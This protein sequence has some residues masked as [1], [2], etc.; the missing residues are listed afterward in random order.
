[1]SAASRFLTM[2]AQALATMSLYR[3]GHPARERAVDR[4]YERLLEL[5]E[6]GPAR[7]FNFLGEDIV[8]E[9]RPLRE[10]RGWDWG[11]RLA[12]AGL[13]RIEFV[14]PVARGDFEAFLDEIFPKVMGARVSSAE[15]R[16]GRP[17]AIRYGHLGVR[18]QEEGGEEAG[19]PPR[20]LADA[21]LRYSLAEE[22]DGVDWLHRE[23]QEGRAL[24]LLEAECIVR[25]LAVAMHS[26]HA[27]LLPILR[28]KEYDQYTVTH[29]LNV[30]VLTM[31]LA[32]FLGMAPREVRA[33]GIAG[34]LHDLGK[35]TIPDDILNK[36]GKLT[37]EERAV[38]NSHTVEGARIILEAEERLDMPAIVAYEHH[39]RIDGGGYPDLRYRRGCHHAS[40]LVHVCDVFDALR[41]DR[42]YR[43]AWSTERALGII[44]EGAG[45]EFDADIAHAFVRMMRQ[46]EDRVAE[47][48]VDD[49]RL[50][51]PENARRKAQENGTVGTG[52]APE[53][54]EGGPEG[55]EARDDPA[56][57]GS[58]AP[59]GL[60]SDAPDARD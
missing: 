32:E 48:D 19:A 30:S 47:V 44:E 54:G 13:Q 18:G 46:W 4:A 7:S 29:A 26:D 20:E 31:A 51:A 17:S 35:V 33:F 45:P 41:T 49:P 23:L 40:N 15:T 59:E 38:M 3:E 21:A 42:P 60:R 52:G 24:Q 37:D 8:L 6:D 22:M 34:L 39:I 28:L 5:Q 27:F 1:M 58:D 12:G 56:G 2:L 57:P 43:S 55:A 9:D 11:P 36:P 50:V 53:D 16:Q 14:G 25:S 10:L